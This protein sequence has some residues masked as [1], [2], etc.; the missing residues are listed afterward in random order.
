MFCK[1]DF[2]IAWVND[3]GCYLYDGRQV[4]NLIEKGGQFYGSELTLHQAVQ[5]QDV[6]EIEC[7]VEDDS[8]K[9]NGRDNRGWMPIHYAVEL[10]N[11]EIC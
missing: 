4:I 11:K 9:I 7:L 6:D 10:G 5:M 2:G 3:L 8:I 1:T